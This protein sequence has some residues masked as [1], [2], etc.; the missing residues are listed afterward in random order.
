MGARKAHTLLECGAE[1]DLVAVSIGEEARSLVGLGLHERPYR[2]G[3]AAAYRLVVSATGDAALDRSICEEAEG[4]GAWALAASGGAGSVAMPAVLR[5]GP[6]AVAVSTSSA[7]PGYAAWLRDSLG[8]HVRP[9]HGL[10]AAILGEVREELRAA[11][12]NA[13]WHRLRI[14]DMLVL[15]REGQ[16]GRAKELVRRCL[17]S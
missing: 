15:L 10:A 16:V 5:R 14:S 4:A 8:E 7:A 3:E 11:G 2:P 13:D 12:A 6:L 17:S 9:E 1:V